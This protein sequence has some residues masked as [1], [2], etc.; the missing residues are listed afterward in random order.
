[1]LSART[2]VTAQADNF[3]AVQ[4]E[5]DF[6]KKIRPWDGFGFNYVETAQTI[7]YG[8]DKQEY[9][10]F[11]LLKEAD[12]QRILQLVFGED[13]LKVGLLKMF[14]DPHH[15]QAANGAFDHESS[16]QWIRQFARE[17]LK[18]TR[19][20]GADLQIITTLYGPPPFVTKQKTM[21]GR[22]LDPA[23]KSALSQYLVDWATY[24]KEKEKL[25]VRYISLHNEGED[26]FRWDPVDETGNIGHGHDY[27]MFWSPALVAEFIKRVRTDLDKAG[28]KDVGV[29]PGENTNWYRWSHW[30]YANAIADDPQA[31]QN[32]GLITSHGFY[33]GS[34]GRWFGE[35]TS[36]GTDLLREKRPE[37]HAWVTSTSWSGM[38]TKNVKE[39]HGNIY[40]AKVNGIIPWA[41]IQRP[42][43]WVGG[44]P[45]PGSAFTVREDGTYEIRRG[46]YFYKQLTRA[47]QPGMAVARTSSMDSEMPIIAFAGNGTANKDAFVVTNMSAFNRRI[48]IAL[49]G[50][51]AKTFTGFRTTEKADRYQNIAEETYKAIGNVSVNAEGNLVY[52]APAGSVTTFFAN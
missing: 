35:H 19:Q 52:E 17:G 46:Y 6:S 1:M 12:R 36:F 24:L 49:K 29:T 26:W 47:G 30:G 51:G 22:D 43:Q 33:V 38:D 31:L 14:Y 34:Y 40:T 8:R 3:T 5:V 13:G 11:S 10:G 21:R 9:G 32:L 15:Q 41:G 42:V 48:V 39:F 27:N 28:L 20:R 18:I 7:N 50:T 16:T 2:A 45:N 37:L 25:P 44:D 23:M 4:A